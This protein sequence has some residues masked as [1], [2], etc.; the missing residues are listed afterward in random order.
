MARL[1]IVLFDVFDDGATIIKFENHILLFQYFF[2]NS[3]R[4]NLFCT[5]IF[6]LPVSLILDLLFC[7]VIRTV[8]PKDFIAEENN[9]VR[10]ILLMILILLV[11][12]HVW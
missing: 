8:Q 12:P 9:Y 7:M 2:L 11:I 10:I 4:I 1:L 6:Q 5:F 3:T